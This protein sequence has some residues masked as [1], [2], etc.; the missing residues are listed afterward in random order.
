M[1]VLVSFIFHVTVKYK[2]QGSYCTFSKCIPSRTHC[3]IDLISFSFA[4]FFKLSCKFRSLVD[5]NC[6]RSIL[7]VSIVK[8]AR[9]VCLESFVFISFVSTVLSK[10]C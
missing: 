1:N 6:F 10:K 5:P 2:F 9:A 3:S 7:F 8:N 4:L